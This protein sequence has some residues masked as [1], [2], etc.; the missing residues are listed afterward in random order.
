MTNTFRPVFFGALLLVVLADF[1]FFGRMIGVSL[2]IFCAAVT[3]A[4]LILH[5]A[6]ARSRTIV[7]QLCLLATTLLPLAENVSPLSF[8]IAVVALSAFALSVAGLLRPG[9]PR[10]ARQIAA[11]LVAAPFGFLLDF[12]RW[13]RKG[14]RA[15]AARLAAWLLPLGLGAVFV[16]LFGI[17]N[18]VVEDWLS[19][20][21]VFALLEHV[22]V[23]RL[24]FWLFVL[25]AVWAFLR[26]R[27][28]YLPA[29][30]PPSP[31]LAAT[32][33]AI[34][35]DATRT[36]GQL[37]FG[38]AAI[39]RALVVFNL[40]F[41]VQSLLDLAYL[42]GGATLPDDLTYAEYAHRGAYPLIV[43]ALLAAFVLAAMRPAGTTSR[44]PVI[45]RL[46]Y[47][48]I[49]Q[50]VLLVIS[51][52]LR[53]D[54]YVGIYALTYW[55]VAALVWMGL[56][57]SGLVLILARIALEKSNGWLFGAN[58]LTLSATLYACSFVNFAALIANYNVDH[59]Y[60]MTGQGVAL[61]HSYLRS[62]GPAA[63]PAIDRLLDRRDLAGT[64]AWIMLSA[65]RQSAED[66]YRETQ[67]D[68]RARTLRGWR[69]TAYLDSRPPQ[70]PAPVTHPT[71]PGY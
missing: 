29:P 31:W 7:F 56:V 17:A 16:A 48:F 60:E 53:L 24:G 39:L 52:I 40:L 33:Q 54:L 38:K 11:F 12:F 22:D 61:D 14:V 8:A 37:V 27:L 67:R 64:D 13:R 62:L 3:A 6:A 41:A 4:M 34:A 23:A 19:R 59:S 58:L 21:D 15:S 42:W 9:I 1:L 49:A 55:R 46:V 68:W 69:L 43:T 45:R 35:P 10:I 25:V 30:Q 57:A 2:L 20:V 28:A 51:S 5:P 71:M 32:P 36:I 47:L 44:D 66:R 65:T 18:P 70:P 50:N 26:P 63:F